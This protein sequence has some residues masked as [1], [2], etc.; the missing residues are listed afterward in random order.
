MSRVFMLHIAASFD[1]S[2]A[3]MIRHDLPV[4]LVVTVVL[5]L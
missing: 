2:A 4:N 1:R 5:S 3:L